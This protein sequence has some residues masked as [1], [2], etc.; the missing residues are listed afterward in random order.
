MMF[1]ADAQAL[2]GGKI[3]SV[4]V[5]ALIVVLDDLTPGTM[6]SFKVRTVKAASS[7]RF[8]QTARNRTFEEGQCSAV[9]SRYSAKHKIVVYGWLSLRRCM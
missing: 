7:S 3:L 4:I 1:V 6:Y 2:P 5:K 8:S 9:Q